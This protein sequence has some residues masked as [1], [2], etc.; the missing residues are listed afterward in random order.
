[1]I[2]KR[3]VCICINCSE[4]DV[5]KPQFMWCMQYATYETTEKPF[6]RVFYSVINHH[7]L[8]T[9]RKIGMSSARRIPNRDV[10]WGRM[11]LLT[12][13]S[14]RACLKYFMAPSVH[15]WTS[16]YAG[17]VLGRRVSENPHT[18]PW[19]VSQDCRQNRE[20]VQS[21]DRSCVNCPKP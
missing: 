9:K 10:D 1:M 11:R 5:A 13:T 20:T 15:C 2:T 19:S 6:C 4:P 16:V 21:P 3:A 7:L 17:L 14:H 12:G 8:E 18:L